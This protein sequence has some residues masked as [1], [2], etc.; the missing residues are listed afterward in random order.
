MSARR[1]IR[2]V[3]GERRELQQLDLVRAHDYAELKWVEDHETGAMVSDA[4][5]SHMPT[6]WRTGGICASFVRR[7][8][9]FE[10]ADLADRR[11]DSNRVDQS[12]LLHLH[13]C[14]RQRRKSH[15]LENGRLSA[16]RAVPHRMAARADGEDWRHDHDDRLAVAR[17]RRLGTFAG[18]NAG[19]RQETVFRPAAGTRRWWKYAGRE[20]DA[21]GTV[22]VGF[23]TR[24]E[25]LNSELPGLRPEV[26][27]GARRRGKSRG[28]SVRKRSKCKFEN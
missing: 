17:W 2:E 11:G 9:R 25:K 1:Q 21:V 27:C 18:S 7:G 6:G 22:S 13:R 14:K 8:I 26:Y 28:R 19:G 5:H 3:L 12:A 16:K 10:Q 4:R 15:E 24:C 23:T 20:S